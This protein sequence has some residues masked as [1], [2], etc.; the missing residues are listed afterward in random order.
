MRS[1]GIDARNGALGKRSSHRVDL[2]SPRI[3]P[4]RADR[5][6]SIVR[7]IVR[8]LAGYLWCAIERYPPGWNNRAGRRY[9]CRGSH[10]DEVLCVKCYITDII[11]IIPSGWLAR[12]RRYVGFEMSLYGSDKRFLET[13]PQL[14]LQSSGSSFLFGDRPTISPSMEH[15]RPKTVRFA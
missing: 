8:P 15:P 9:I 1:A 11:D 6:K 14:W 5:G 4:T 12:M 2:L 13:S 3:L 7:P 10:T